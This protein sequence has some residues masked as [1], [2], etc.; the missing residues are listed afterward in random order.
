[1]VQMI[2]AV[3]QHPLVPIKYLALPKR[4]SQNRQLVDLEA[5]GKPLHLAYNLGQPRPSADA[6]REKQISIMLAVG[7]WAR[8]QPRVNLVHLLLI[9]FLNILRSQTHALRSEE[10]TS[11]LQ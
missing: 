1:Q 11:E 5:G 6:L 10:H 8:C 3:A 4:F 9:E 2:D 7:N